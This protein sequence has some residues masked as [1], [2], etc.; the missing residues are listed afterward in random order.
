MTAPVYHSGSDFDLK[1][2]L[3]IDGQALSFAAAT[4][5]QVSLITMDRTATVAGPI[6]AASNAP[7]ADWPNGIV[8]AVIPLANT[9]SIAPGAYRIK[10]NVTL[11]GLLSTWSDSTIVVVQGVQP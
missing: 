4:L 6:T 11:A 8:T 1:A 2:T 9:G 3:F 7:E 10:V 5:V